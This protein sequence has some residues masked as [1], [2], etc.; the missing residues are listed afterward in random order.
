MPVAVMQAGRVVSCSPAARDGGVVPGL[1]RRE[2]E[3]RCA[4]LVLAD[5]DP[6]RDARAFE[7]IAAAVEEMVP[8]IEIL[9]PGVIAFG[10]RGPARYYGGERALI[11]TV[12]AAAE[13][14]GALGCR[15]GV[16]EG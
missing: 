8:A 2:A 11:D 16:A 4:G 5:H 12:S 9:R 6:L 14:A 7:P 1:R 10:V 15:A 13:R 3:S